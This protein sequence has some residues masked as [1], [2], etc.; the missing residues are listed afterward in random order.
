MSNILIINTTPRKNGNSTML[1]SEFARGAEESGHSVET[2]NLR[3]KSIG[4]CLGCMTC[5]T[6]GKCPIKDDVA[7]ILTAM[8][9]ADKIVWTTPIYF[10]EMAAQMKALIDRT[11]A[12]FAREYNFR[13]VYLIATAADTNEDSMDGA[14]KGLEGWINCF[15]KARLAGV[16]SGLGL[17]DI[18][19]ASEDKKSMK[20]AYDMGRSAK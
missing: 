14:I 16:V 2:I 13:D 5:Q 17:T 8:Q 9:G 15:E 11:N 4:Y 6:K 19:E 7:E 20:A 1:A 10:Y 3:G 12:I 18:G